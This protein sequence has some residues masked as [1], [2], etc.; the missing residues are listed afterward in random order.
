MRVSDNC[1][2]IIMIKLINVNDYKNKNISIFYSVSNSTVT[3][4]IAL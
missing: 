4:R 1:F 2:I 3:G